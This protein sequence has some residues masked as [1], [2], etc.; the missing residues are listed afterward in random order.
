M[1]IDNVGTVRLNVEAYLDPK[2]LRRVEQAVQQHTRSAGKMSSAYKRPLGEITGQ[3]SEFTKSLDASNARVLAFGASAGAIMGLQRAFT[4]LLSSMRDVEKELK[5]I[6]VLL[7]A[8]A[9]ALKGFGQEL[10]KVAG[11]TGQSFQTVAT[12]AKELSRQG[13]KMEETLK[14]TK[15]AMILTRLSGMDAES[16]VQSLTAAMNTFNKSALDSSRIVNK[17]ANVDA[18]FAVSTKDLAEAM[19]R[20]GSTAQ[21][22]RVDFNQLLGAVA[23]LQQ[24]TARGGPVIGNGLKS[25]F[26]RIQRTDTLD[27]LEALRISVR[28]MQGEMLP[29]M[30]VLGNLAKKFPQLTKAQQ[31]HT[32]ETVAGVFQMNTLRALLSDM[33][34][35]QSQYARGVKIANDA[36]NQATIRNT[37]L[38]KTLDA[39]LIKLKA[40]FVQAGK[41]LGDS[42]LGPSVDRLVGGVDAIF[43][44]IE[45]KGGGGKS[46][47]IKIAKG[48]VDGLGQFLAGPGLALLGVITFNL[49]TRLFKFIKE[50]A[51]EMMNLKNNTMQVAY[52]EEKISTALQGQTQLL[53]AVNKGVITRRQAENHILAILKQQHAE[54]K[55]AATFAAQTARSV[56]MSGGG[57]ATGR[58]NKAAGTFNPGRGRGGARGFIPNFNQKSSEIMGAISGGY[59]PGAVKQTKIA[60]LGN[61][62]YNT[63][64]KIKHVPGFAQPFIN[65][66]QHSPAGKSHKQASLKK[67]GMDPYSIP[68][69][70]KIPINKQKMLTMQ[71]VLT[72]LRQGPGKAARVFSI[73][74]SDGSVLSGRQMKRKNYGIGGGESHSQFDASGDYKYFRFQKKLGDPNSWVESRVKDISQLNFDGRRYIADP[75]Q[76]HKGLPMLRMVEAPLKTQLGAHKGL[77][78]NFAKM[79][80]S[81]G[82]FNVGMTSLYGARPTSPT[83]GGPGASGLYPRYA[84]SSF[85]SKPSKGSATQ[86]GE[87]TAQAY[88]LIGKILTGFNMKMPLGLDKPGMSLGPG[89]TLGGSSPLA[90]FLPPTVEVTSTA[91]KK[92][93]NANPTKA[94][95]IKSAASGA[96]PQEFFQTLNTKI[97]PTSKS[98]GKFYEDLLF[99]SG[100]PNISRRFSGAESNV[101]AG[102]DPIEGALRHGGKWFPMDVKSTATLDARATL[103]GKAMQSFPSH[104]KRV[105]KEIA[106][107]KNKTDNGSF[108]SNDIRIIDKFFD[109]R[110]GVGALKT[111]VFQQAF[112]N[113]RDF[114]G[115]RGWKTAADGFVP[116]F[117]KGMSRLSKG[118]MTKTSQTEVVDNAMGVRYDK[119]LADLRNGRI[120]STS[121]VTARDLERAEYGIMEAA[122]RFNARDMGQYGFNPFLGRGILK[123]DADPVLNKL[124][125]S[126]GHVPN[127]APGMFGKAFRGIKDYAQYGYYM[128]QNIL[129]RRSAM[130]EMREGQARKAQNI[131]PERAQQA[132]KK[133]MDE[134]IRGLK[135]QG[136]WPLG[137][138]DKILTKDPDTGS[139]IGPYISTGSFSRGHIPN[140]ADPISAAFTREKKAS[141]LGSGQI[142][143]TTVDTPNYSGPVVG[144]KRD[145]PTYSSLRKAVMDHPNP[146]RA[147]MSGGFVPNFNPLFAMGGYGASALGFDSSLKELEK[148]LQHGTEEQKKATKESKDRGKEASKAQNRLQKELNNL[149][150]LRTVGE[151]VDK[152]GKG[153]IHATADMKNV[154]K[155]FKSHYGKFLGQAQYVSPTGEQ[156]MVTQG[157]IDNMANRMT[158]LIEGTGSSKSVQKYF[159]GGFEAAESRSARKLTAVDSAKSRLQSDIGKHQRTQKDPALK[160]LGT[161]DYVEKRLQTLRAAKATAD[162]RG[163]KK[164]TKAYLRRE[165]TLSQLERFQQRGGQIDAARANI[166]HGQEQ[167]LREMNKATRLPGIRMGELYGSPAH[168]KE[169]ARLLDERNRASAKAKEASA[170]SRNAA[171]QQAKLKEG[172]A[173]EKKRGW[174]RRNA[175][176]IGS[177]GMSIG[178]MA[179]MVAGALA[180]GVN[181]QSKAGRKKAAKIQGVG[182]VAGFA[183]M[184]AMIGS[185]IAP[186]IGT[187]IGGVAG[188]LVGAYS[189]IQ[190]MSQASKTTTEDLERAYK[191]QTESLN[192]NLA[193]IQKY[194]TAQIKLN[195]ALRA[196]A[197]PEVMGALR[198]N[199]TE[200]LITI[201]DPNIIA[202]LTAAG[203]DVNRIN[204]ITA[205]AADKK[206]RHDQQMAA[207]K[208]VVELVQREAFGSSDELEAI[209]KNIALSG[210]FK[211]KSGAGL[212]KA[213]AGRGFDFS[214]LKPGSVNIIM[215]A[216]KRFEDMEDPASDFA[217][218]IEESV[219]QV[220][221]FNSQM[222][223]VLRLRDREL[224]VTEKLFNASIKLSE[225]ISN[226]RTTTDPNVL[227][228]NRLQST[229]I[230][231]NDKFEMSQ[232]KLIDVTMMDIVK[233]SLKKNKG[234]IGYGT[235]DQT[236]IQKF[237]M[238]NL[239]AGNIQENINKFFGKGGGGAD[240]SI[241]END[242]LKAALFNLGTQLKLNEMATATSNELARTQ[243][244][245]SKSNADFM[246]RR[247]MVQ[248]GLSQ[249][250][251]DAIN[252]IFNPATLTKTSQSGFQQSAA[253][254]RAFQGLGQMGMNFDTGALKAF[255]DNA[256]RS[257]FNRNAT[258]VLGGMLGGARANL[259]KNQNYEQGVETIRDAN[260]RQ[261][262]TALAIWRGMK[263]PELDKEREGIKSEMAKSQSELRDNLFQALGGNTEML[264][265]VVDSQER[266]IQSVDNLELTVDEHPKSFKEAY[267]G[268]WSL[269][270]NQAAK[271]K[272]GSA[273]SKMGGSIGP[274]AIKEQMMYADRAKGVG[275]P[276]FHAA[277]AGAYKKETKGFGLPLVNRSNKTTYSGADFGGTFFDPSGPGSGKEEGAPSSETV[278]DPA[279]ALSHTTISNPRGTE[280][281]GPGAAGGYYT[282]TEEGR[283]ER[284]AA[285][286]KSRRINAF[287]EKQ[288]GRYEA[289]Q[290]LSSAFKDMPQSVNN[291]AAVRKYL[292]DYY[293]QQGGPAAMSEK[294]GMSQATYAE[295]G[296]KAVQQ[297]GQRKGPAAGKKFFDGSG[298]L[299]QLGTEY[300]SQ[301]RQRS[302]TLVRMASAAKGFTQPEDLQSAIKQIESGLPQNVPQ[303]LKGALNPA[304]AEL[305]NLRERLAALNAPKPAAPSGGAP[306]PK[307][308]AA[309]NI[310]AAQKKAAEA[311]ARSKANQEAR[312]KLA[313][314][315]AKLDKLSTPEDVAGKKDTIDYLGRTQALGDD[316]R[317][318]AAF[319]MRNLGFDKG[320]IQATGKSFVDTQRE[321]KRQLMQGERK[322]LLESEELNITDDQIAEK[323]KGAE[324]KEAK[325]TEMKAARTLAQDQLQSLDEDLAANRA[326]TQQGQIDDIRRRGATATMAGPEAARAM[327]YNADQQILDSNMARIEQLRKDIETADKDGTVTEELTK[328]KNELKE[329]LSQVPMQTFNAELSKLNDSIAATR[330]LLDGKTGNL[331]DLVGARLESQSVN[332][333]R[334]LREERD[335]QGDGRTIGNQK[336]QERLNLSR[337]QTGIM[338]GTGNYSQLAAAQNQQSLQSFRR[339]DI[340]MGQS[341]ERQMKSKVMANNKDWQERLMADVAKLS[342]SI[343][344]SFEDAWDSWISG[345]KSGKDAFKA[346]AAAVAMDMQRILF[347]ATVGRVIENVVSGSIGSISGGLGN[348]WR[349]SKGGLVPQRFNEGGFVQGGSGYKDDVPA[350]MSGGEFVMRKSA[351]NKYGPEFMQRLNDPGSADSMMFAKG[352]VMNM[353]T[354]ET[355]REPIPM[356]GKLVVPSMMQGPQPI[357]PSVNWDDKPSYTGRS[358]APPAIEKGRDR[359]FKQQLENQYLMND[360]DR[361]G[362]AKYNVDKRL[363]NFAQ[364]R[365][366]SNVQSKFRQ[367]RQDKFLAY[368]DFLKMETDRRVEA[369]GAFEKQR[370]DVLKAGRLNAIISAVS[371]LAEEK[372]GEWAE[373]ISVKNAAKNFDAGKAPKTPQQFTNQHGQTWTHDPGTNSIRLNSNPAVS[374]PSPA[375]WLRARHP[376]QTMTG[377][378]GS[379]QIQWGIGIPTQSFSGHPSLDDFARGGRVKRFA[380]GGMNRDSVPA[381]LM[382]GEYV[383]NKESAQTY[384][385]EFLNR[386]NGG[387]IPTFQDGGTVGGGLFETAGAGGDPEKISQLVDLAEN[388]NRMME[389]SITKEDAKEEET[390]ETGEGGGS[391]KVAGGMVNNISITVNSAGGGVGGGEPTSEVDTSTENKDEEGGSNNEENTGDLERNEKL[392]DSLRGVVLDTIVKEQ[393][394]G[395]L[396]HDSK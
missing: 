376:N 25:I 168:M 189:M 55:A 339:G 176:A 19:K 118:S 283:R 385:T 326:A 152:L 208:G 355:N 349:G 321:A 373:G 209:A 89:G 356:E 140:F 77:I 24:T 115:A 40:R 10:F 133:E 319:A 330:D 85:F 353:P 156:K 103:G 52:V 357:L 360:P 56:V 97:K 202:K 70:A 123:R 204:E 266:L 132:Q 325:I 258:G 247:G 165:R 191:G 181:T 257:Q 285:D 290:S 75:H 3:V 148:A 296:I 95:A 62:T 302:A 139:Y 122:P 170:N 248:G 28:D 370:S 207:R 126:G 127:F 11:S 172:L 98:S 90:N 99:A 235:E 242:E 277:L 174:F 114:M 389:E 347:R 119:F 179:P 234:G 88:S 30:T 167:R 59:F 223:E 254:G 5:D 384:G 173:A 362:K 337:A 69:F 80:P 317:I 368:E 175:G 306:G 243:N 32:A 190:S 101:G 72:T 364:F 199:L 149:K 231:N 120:K 281:S 200:M 371:V 395:G 311:T 124:G 333:D 7:N 203:G 263:S 128:P 100:N 35:T 262:N 256:M 18:A 22:V 294:T 83:S 153:Q 117:A 328:K 275:S 232:R 180:S 269:L 225:A 329:A 66:P 315:R 154:V 61:I 259:M 143:A 150:N 245:I 312:A 104:Y 218:S 60:G 346:F 224:V 365:D 215:D 278:A 342:D 64:E 14:R 238:E 260:S 295:T 366:D 71:E 9:T 116:N 44:G 41:G 276:A 221:R 8:D 74:K 396:L 112:N 37:E 31:A 125:Y 86:L 369:Q 105:I 228:N 164:T 388:M 141:G 51:L 380:N 241:K 91:F 212:R 338:T 201:G 134:F 344:G 273:A 135:N 216:I 393:R 316:Y 45:K 138:K 196:G 13:L 331:S 288:R 390:Q 65:P 155:D 249:D 38:N 34:Q 358:G 43:D 53:V 240:L 162:S 378:I 110:S 121:G 192:S 229:L 187:V 142:Y 345:S 236:L 29:A 217:E 54:Q 23:S 163:H 137:P 292:E 394:P 359:G 136:R 372:L 351:V 76:K 322:R 287:H 46:L 239:G 113:A 102:L 81:Y 310:A 147:G 26:T 27:Q 335:K 184:G 93:L 270:A 186:G 1:A 159:R 220:N 49:G 377:L 350:M 109:A 92:L 144:N 320:G 182:N 219:K 205:V 169:Q 379:G 17:M 4:F 348:A 261:G 298:G 255:K 334:S 84:S 214:E 271:G 293:E 129:Y 130:K 301:L 323:F 73:T 274:A 145:E 391:A 111:P 375:H 381:M 94:E 361:P 171:Q 267:M 300:Q 193:A 197:G 297:W 282:N 48:L 341:L 392:A 251:F 57:V 374:Y 284:A 183:G 314:G 161:A 264:G 327:G 265:L 336:K 343:T 177:M 244:A 146:A 188:G 387:K 332:L 158:N 195:D 47:G 194:T 79:S 246:D 250:P 211:G 307:P 286:E 78:P 67:L 178:F 213:V 303:Q 253:T 280:T 58:M 304:Q 36:T 324:N 237:A 63:A 15:D 87:N 6:N 39:Q 151:S 210:D 299:T 318:N 291:E 268:A 82:S 108:S 21:D 227:A 42:L 96:S 352:G 33:G 252:Q 313:A 107:W 233:K 106:Q 198:K 272:F 157:H 289:F 354:E 226:L 230:G 308:A 68:S 382:G 16:A 367:T 279:F 363:S 2:S 12:A 386:L 166:E 383:L 50:S 160:R 309:A 131:P 206:I 222:N 305:K 340:N 185:S 20:V